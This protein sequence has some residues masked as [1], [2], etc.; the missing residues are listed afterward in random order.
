MDRLWDLHQL[1]PIRDVHK[2]HA[3]VT[4]Q[5]CFG[6]LYFREYKKY[7]SRLQSTNQSVTQ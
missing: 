2:F 1:N 5:I 6:S 3:F 4:F 7:L